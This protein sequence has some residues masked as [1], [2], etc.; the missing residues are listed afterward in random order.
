MFNHLVQ[1]RRQT[2]DPYKTITAT[3]EISTVDGKHSNAGYRQSCFRTCDWRIYRS[4]SV[5]TDLEQIV[6]DDNPNPP[7]LNP[8]A[9]RI[10][11][12]WRQITIG[13][14]TWQ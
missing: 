1:L 4:Q 9:G 11:I 14:S 5:Y 8:S 2:L 7:D 6:S 13:L 3:T 12:E 10:K